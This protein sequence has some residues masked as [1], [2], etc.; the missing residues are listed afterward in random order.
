MGKEFVVHIGYPKTGTTL[1][2]KHIYPY[3]K[4]FKYLNYKTCH[5]LFY[6]VIYKDELDYNSSLPL[7]TLAPYQ[8]HEK[9]FA[10]YESLTGPLWF[11]GLNR[12]SI[13]KRLKGLGVT[14]VIITIRHQVHEIDSCYRQYIQEG[15]I[16][17]F[18]GALKTEEKYSWKNMI[19]LDY[20]NYYSLI[21]LYADTFGKQNILIIPSE[22]LKK[23]LVGTVRDIEAFIGSSALDE[24]HLKRAEQ[25]RSN[26]S[27][28]NL[29]LN[30]L[31]LTNHFTTSKFKPNN[32]I[33]NKITTWKVRH[34]LQSKID[35]LLP[36]SL[37]KRKNFISNTNLKNKIRAYYSESNAAL[38][39]EFDLCLKDLGYP[40]NDDTSCKPA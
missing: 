21:Q 24:A 35:P 15:G 16:L 7:K 36:Q 34:L 37:S 32:L 12:S 28:T 10:S 5:E 38:E 9:L 2:Q 23:D 29:S 31:R 14:K 26:K 11:N 19:D 8:S 18:E 17:S 30:F 39:E 40:I 1:L 6:T 13:P 3:F 22:L 33:T 27:L 20:F 25:H 4:D